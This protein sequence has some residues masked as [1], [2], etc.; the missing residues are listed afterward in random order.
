MSNYYAGR[1]SDVGV[2]FTDKDLVSKPTGEGAEAVE[3][4]A[5]AI[6][7]AADESARRCGGGRGGRGLHNDGG[8]GWRNH[9]LCHRRHGDGWDAGRSDADQREHLLR[10]ASGNADDVDIPIH[11]AHVSAYVATHV[12][13]HGTTYAIPGPL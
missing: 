10:T 12:A 2:S 11:V 1:S 4:A 3:E 5:G 8:D 6:E 7:R 13:V 9:G